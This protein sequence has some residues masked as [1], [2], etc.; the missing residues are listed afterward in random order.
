M[1]PRRFLKIDRQ[2]PELVPSFDWG[3][4]YDEIEDDLTTGVLAAHSAIVD[5]CAAWLSSG[6][7]IVW[8]RLGL[9]RV[10]PSNW[11]LNSETRN[12]AARCHW[13]AESYTSPFGA[14]LHG[15]EVGSN[16]FEDWIRFLK[17]DEHYAV[18]FLHAIDRTSTMQI[19]QRIVTLESSKSYRRGRDDGEDISARFITV[20]NNMKAL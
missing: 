5:A 8:L 10:F 12:P 16:F 15:S 2:R 7:L 6:G 19:G 13:K 17:V 3:G 1:K 9:T 4:D 11:L 18:G 14:V 20:V